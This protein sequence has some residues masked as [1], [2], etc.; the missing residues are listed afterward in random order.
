MY[1]LNKSLGDRVF[2]IIITLVMSILIFVTVWPFWAQLVTSLNEG[3]TSLT[4]AFWPEKFSIDAYKIMLGYK[5]IWN[6][7]K[8]SILRVVL[9]TLIGLVLTILMAYPL[10]K[11][12]LPF[13][14]FMTFFVV[15]T[16]LFA[17]GMIP[18][19][20]T[21]K[22][23]QLINT[24]WVLVLP[25]CLT[26]WNTLLMRNFFISI[27]KSLEESAKIDGARY[28]SILWR[29]IIPLSTPI[30]ATIALFIAVHQWNEWFNAMMWVTDK[31]LYVLQYVLKS[32][33]ES[34][35]T[36]EVGQLMNQLSDKQFTP[37]QLESAIIIL[38]ILPMLI[39]YPFIQKF[40]TKGIMVGAVKS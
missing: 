9:S 32:F 37:R 3:Y 25:N 13:N 12:E 17:G 29:I 6:G 31:K 39:V 36:V 14:K 15:F 7:F 16:M 26:A 20:I 11:K 28:L 1:A 8:I 40:F 4:A 38:T 35:K 30:I 34:S 2:N 22:K 5:S 19:Y 24:I 10:S 23:M 27:P 21:L 33:I 18:S